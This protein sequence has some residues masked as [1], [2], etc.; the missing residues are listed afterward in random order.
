MDVNK[1]AEIHQDHTYVTVSRDTLLTWIGDDVMVCVLKWSY[2]WLS[3][4]L[5][6]P[7]SYTP[8]VYVLQQQN[9]VTVPFYFW[10][11]ILSFDKN[12]K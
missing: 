10:L 8:V 9:I 2:F 5:V 11:K 1:S 12:E 3:I 7:T 6:E 4:N